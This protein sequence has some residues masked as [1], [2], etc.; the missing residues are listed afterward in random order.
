[1][2]VTRGDRTAAVHI[3][4]PNQQPAAGKKVTIAYIDEH[5]GP[6]PV[7][8]GEVPESGTITLENIAQ[9]KKMPL[10]GFS[11]YI[12]R[13]GGESLGQFNFTDDQKRGEFSFRL[14]IG[15]GDDAPD[16]DLIDVNTGKHTR[17]SEFRGKG[18]W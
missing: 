10:M 5:Y 1:M 17:L 13:A 18:V 4:K 11:G 15:V 6:I 3:V 14:P 12:V 7:F 16:L 2:N 8:N 9:G